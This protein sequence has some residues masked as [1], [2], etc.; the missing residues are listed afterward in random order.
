MCLTHVCVCVCV[1]SA[2]ARLKE[3]IETALKELSLERFMT[4]EEHLYNV[5]ALCTC[6]CVCVCV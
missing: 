5:R 6:V 1:C 2:C 3:H 4:F